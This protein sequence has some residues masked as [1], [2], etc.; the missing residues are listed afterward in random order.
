M[1]S[2][3]WHDLHIFYCAELL[4]NQMTRWEERKDIFS[5]PLEPSD[6]SQYHLLGCSR[7]CLP[8]LAAIARFHFW[9]GGRSGRWDITGEIC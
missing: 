1:S 2:N 7:L 5:T 9:L 4:S 3:L 8:L 6:S